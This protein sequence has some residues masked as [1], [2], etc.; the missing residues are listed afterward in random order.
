MLAHVTEMGELLVERIEAL[1]SPHIKEVRGLGLMIGIQL[2][3]DAAPLM[4]AGYEHGLIVLN[5]G[6]EVMRLLPPLIVTEADIDHFINV[7]KDIL[8]A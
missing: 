5:A 6:P 1:G 7:L 4:Q 2:D 3:I 8:P